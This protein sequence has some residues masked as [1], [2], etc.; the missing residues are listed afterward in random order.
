MDYIFG[1]L[2]LIPIILLILHIC[3]INSRLYIWIFEAEAHKACKYVLDNINYLKFKYVDEGDYRFELLGSLYTIWLWQ[4]G[5]VSIFEG[6]R[7]VF[8]GGTS[9]YY[10][11]KLYFA[12]TNEFLTNIINYSKVNNLIK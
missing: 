9:K 1:I 3:I 2:I 5:K 4:E 10:N 8:S 12:I 6:R 7:C 11:R